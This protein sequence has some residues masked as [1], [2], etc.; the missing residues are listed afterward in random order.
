MCVCVCVCVCVCW[1]FSDRERE[2]ARGIACVQD[3][4][5]WLGGYHMIVIMIY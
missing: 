5:I 2:E 3:S 4:D 1:P